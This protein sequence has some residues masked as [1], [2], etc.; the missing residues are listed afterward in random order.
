LRA[1]PG[2]RRVQVP[3]TCATPGRPGPPREH[4]T[5]HL[6]ALRIE[7]CP[8]CSAAFLPMPPVSCP[9]AGG[10]SAGIL[11]GSLCLIGRSD[12]LTRRRIGLLAIEPLLVQVAVWTPPLHHWFFASMTVVG[13]HP[14]EL[15]LRYGPLF[16]LHSVYSYAL[17]VVASGLLARSFTRSSGI[18]RRQVG[19]VLVATLIPWVANAGTLT[20]AG[21]GLHW[22]AHY[23]LTPVAFTLTGLLMAWALFRD[24]MFDLV[25]VARDLVVDTIKDAVIVIDARSRVTDANPAADT[26]LHE[27]NPTLPR[28]AVGI[29]AREAFAGWPGELAGAMAPF[30]ERQPGGRAAGPAPEPMPAQQVALDAAGHTRHFHARRSVLVDRR[31][32]ATGYLLV[33]HDESEIVAAQQELAGANDGLRRQLDT[34]EA[35]RAELQE[36][37]IHDQLTGLYNRR[38]LDE[39]IGREL[40]RSQRNGDPLS[41]VFLDVDHFK[42]VNDVYGHAA[43]DAVIGAVGEILRTAVRGS[44]IACRYGGDEFVVLMPKAGREVAVARAES[45]RR[46]V[47]TITVPAADGRPDNRPRIQVACSIGV[48]TAPWDGDTVDDLLAAAD[49]ALY[50]AKESGRDQVSSPAARPAEEATP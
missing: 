50:A 43:G 34:I 1:P 36:L 6:P 33:L 40:K 37:A 16:W 21:A 10:G 32:A 39:T 12:W 8:L 2:V 47:G 30:D 14:V 9:H 11:S 4:R 42:S 13:T 49:A 17:L 28:S 44:D 23:D 35:L 24:Q 26:L 19:T 41:V 15:A 5:R 31:G 25:P 45:W 22:L 18:Y 7:R 27:L 38:F 29:P 46:M 3:A 48:A 20:G